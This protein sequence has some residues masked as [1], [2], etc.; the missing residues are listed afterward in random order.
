MVGSGEAHFWP[1]VNS[2]VVTEIIRSPRKH[3]LNFFLAA[4]NLAE[5][6][7]MTPIILEWGKKKRGCTHAILTGRSGW[8]R[9][10]LAKSGWKTEPYI[11]MEKEL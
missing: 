1:G 10:F 5:L 7:A 6:E 2:C 8:Q 11:V 9:T 4:G 3:F